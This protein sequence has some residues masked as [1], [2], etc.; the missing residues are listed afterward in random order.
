MG[1]A[2]SSALQAGSSALQVGHHTDPGSQ[3]GWFPV[4]VDISP[5]K[6][7]AGYILSAGSMDCLD[8]SLLLGQKPFLTSRSVLSFPGREDF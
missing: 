6:A 2:G 1:A 8:L 3:A 4:D 7:L 5:E